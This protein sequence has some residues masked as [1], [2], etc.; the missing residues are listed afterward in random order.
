MKSNI[1]RLGSVSIIISSFLLFGF[2]PLTLFPSF[3]LTAIFSEIVIWKELIVLGTSVCFVFFGRKEHFDKVTLYELSFGCF[4]W[5]GLFVSSL[6]FRDVS[7][8]ACFGGSIPYL[9][10]IWCLFVFRQLRREAMLLVYFGLILAIGFVSFGIIYD[11]L[12]GAFLHIRAGGVYVERAF[13]AVEEFRRPGFLMSGSTVASLYLSSVTFLAYVGMF[14][15]TGL[16]CRFIIYCVCALAVLSVLVT[17]GRVGYAGIAVFVVTL[18]VLSVVLGQWKTF[19]SITA[20]GCVVL[21]IVATALLGNDYVRSSVEVRF[22]QTFGKG[23]VSSAADRQRIDA[24]KNGIIESVR[25]LPIGAGI[26]QSQ[27]RLG[28][29]QNVRHF[30]SG[31]IS[32]FYESGVFFIP[33]ISFVLLQV[34]KSMFNLISY[35][36]GKAVAVG[37]ISC[38]FAVSFM[39]FINPILGEVFFAVYLAYLSNYL[40]L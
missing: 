32:F 19:R 28:N 33:Y 39:V 29:S 27:G 16:K 2:V 25:Q 9:I 34:F 5:G 15:I 20:G 22:K 6:I 3:F 10:F 12:T 40:S 35:K 26:G 36:E 11:A 1:S 30:E 21:L 14:K 13:T 7:L 8:F 23:V 18:S 31:V 37:L 24:W 4:C 17:L 38:L